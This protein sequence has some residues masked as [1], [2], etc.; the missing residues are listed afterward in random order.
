VPTLIDRSGCSCASVQC[1]CGLHGGKLIK[2]LSIRLLPSVVCL[3]LKRF[4]WSAHSCLKIQ[5]LVHFPLESFDLARFCEIGE[6]DSTEL[7]MQPYDLIS[8]IS[9]HGSNLGSGHYTAICRNARTGLWHKYNDARV[10]TLT[11]EEVPCPPSHRFPTLC[12]Y[13]CAW[14]AGGA[15]DWRAQQVLKEQ[16]YILFYARKDSVAAA[17][18]AAA[19]AVA[20]VGCGSAPAAQAAADA[21]PDVGAPTA[22]CTETAAAVAGAEAVMTMAP[23]TPAAETTIAQTVSAAETSMAES[24]IDETSE[25]ATQ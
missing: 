1:S 3:H 16:A 7:S 21:R 2:R 12:T 17:A 5:T 25:N 11:A 22:A 18:A 24:A 9:H 10:S 6:A 19:G 13:R 20:A 8:M 14:P 4:K 23:T 15:V